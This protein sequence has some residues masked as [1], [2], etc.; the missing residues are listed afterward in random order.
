ML[1]ATEQAYTYANGSPL[2]GT[3]PQGLDS[4][5]GLFVLDGGPLGG[6]GA[7]LLYAITH[8]NFIHPDGQARL[9]RSK[10]GVPNNWERSFHFDYHPPNPPYHHF[11]AEFGW[12]KKYDPGYKPFISVHPAIPEGLYRLGSNAA[13]RG[14]GRATL[15]LS[16]LLDIFELQNAIQNEP[17]HLGRVIGGILGGWGGGLLGAAL[18]GAASAGIGTPIGGFVGGAVGSA[19]GETIGDL[20][21]AQRR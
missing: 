21:D 12:L 17:C 4:L 6:F 5:S 7:G 8:Q 9:G 2:N 18:G 19:L 11:N 3:D 15:A 10:A 13:L 16:L 20:I 14:L 1:A